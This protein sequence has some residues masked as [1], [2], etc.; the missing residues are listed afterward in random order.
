MPLTRAKKEEIVKDLKDRIKEASLV[1][2]ANFHGFS[3]AKAADLRKLLRKESGSYRVAKKTLLD[4]AFR[5]SNIAIPKKLEGEIGVVFGAGDALQALKS[6]V[7][8]A[9]ASKETFRILGGIFSAGGGER[10]YIDELAVKR[11][12]LIPSREILLAQLLNVF[13]AP[14]SG[15][16]RVFRGVERN[17]VTML[18]EIAKK[19]VDQ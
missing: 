11:L 10:P 8:F 12:S 1:L 17:F 15:L 19:K 7:A 3:V 5:E 4:I 6:V 14:A 2:F 16:V 9:K 13:S 18:S